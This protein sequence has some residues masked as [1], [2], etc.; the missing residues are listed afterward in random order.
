MLHHLCAP[1]LVLNVC[2]PPLVLNVCAKS[3]L[4]HSNGMHPVCLYNSNKILIFYLASG[5]DK[6][7]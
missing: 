5:D 3:Q 2:A 7:V 1:P 4:L 6:Q